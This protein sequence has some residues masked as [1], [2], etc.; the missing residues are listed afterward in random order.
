M[1]IGLIIFGV[2]ILTVVY[3]VWSF[4]I[5]TLNLVGLEV[6]PFLWLTVLLGTFFAIPYSLA[7]IINGLELSMFKQEERKNV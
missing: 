4:S 3:G 5:P 6:S 1:K 7:M 2:L